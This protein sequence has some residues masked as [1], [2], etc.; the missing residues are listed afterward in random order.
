MEWHAESDEIRPIPD[1]AEAA[2][3]PQD[4]KT[5][6][7]LYLTGLHL[8]QYRH[9]TWSALDYYEEALR[10]DPLDYRCNMQTGLWYLRRA[11]FEKA[12]PYLQTAVRVLKKR[13]PN[14]YDG[15]PLFYLGLVKRF[16][17]QMHEAYELFWKSTWNKGWADAGYFEA[18][19]LS[20]G[21]KRYEAALDEVERSLISNSHNHKARALKAVVIRIK[22]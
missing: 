18:A 10:R 17:H 12:E 2:L 13:N 14:P 21:A 4:T 9:A 3:S 22:I 16:L 11:R 15:E 8:E 6:D 7:Q 20:M 19:C 1:A 5:I